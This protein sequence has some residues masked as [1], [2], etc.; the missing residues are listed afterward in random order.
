MGQVDLARDMATR[1]NLDRILAELGLHLNCS[2]NTAL[3]FRALAFLDISSTDSSTGTPSTPKRVASSSLAPEKNNMYDRFGPDSLRHRQAHWSTPPLFRPRLTSHTK[4]QYNHTSPLNHSSPTHTAFASTGTQ[5]SHPSEHPRFS[6]N[7]FNSESSI[8]QDYNPRPVSQATR[9]GS[10]Q[11]WPDLSQYTIT[12]LAKDTPVLFI[13]PV[14][15][16]MADGL[17]LDREQCAAPQ[18]NYSL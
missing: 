15:V 13:P 1:F 8:L 2:R 3:G 4:P 7:P 17:P 18:G 14:A 16:T 9:A 10:Q 12:S 6:L 11:P 5:C